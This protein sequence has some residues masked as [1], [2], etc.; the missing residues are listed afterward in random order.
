MKLV[1]A[2]LIIYI[3]INIMKVKQL[4]MASALLVLVSKGDSSADLEDFNLLS[5][6]SNFFQERYNKADND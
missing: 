5:A 2:Q 6:S 1:I 4:S 3:K